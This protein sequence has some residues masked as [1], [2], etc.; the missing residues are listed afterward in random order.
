[1][2]L[3]TVDRQIE[4]CWNIVAMLMAR[5]AGAEALYE[6]NPN[7]SS[8]YIVSPSGESEKAPEVTVAGYTWYDSLFGKTVD[9]NLHLRM[10]TTGM[11]AFT[12]FNA[13]FQPR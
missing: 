9:I 1:M 6:E 4:F 3:D 5:N 13:R 7:V 10:M 11:Y 2:L 12:R 8:Q